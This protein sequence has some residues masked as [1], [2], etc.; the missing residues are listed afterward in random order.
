MFGRDP[1]LVGILCEP[2]G[3]HRRT[4]RTAII[5]INAGLIHRVG[6]NRVY[7]RLARHLASMGYQSLRF[8]LSGRGDSDVRRNAMGFIEGSLADVRA[9]MDLLR[10][11]IGAERFVLMGI[12]SG[13]IN[14]LHA[15]T[16]DPR[17]VGTIA[18]DGPAHQTF[19]YYA[20][21]YARRAL[22]G[23][24][25]LNILTGRNPLKRWLR[26]P[27]P[28]AAPARAEDE[29]AHLYGEL[30]LPSREESERVLQSVIDRG[31]RMLFIYTGS[32]SIYNYANQ[33]RDAFPELMKRGAIRV[34]YAPDADHT[35]T[36]PHH[37]Q[38][39]V[40]MVTAW[41]TDNFSDEGDT[42]REVADPATV[43]A[44]R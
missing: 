36:R 32:W 13:A 9:A 3:E 20:R 19:G 38:R 33:F 29:F 21:H 11:T 2:A 35:F 27:S 43:G 24:A 44:E 23:R 12:C 18:I 30:K 37:Q 42:S 17:V 28:A 22:S 41:V 4:R 5:F 34:E 10:E 25:W 15:A 40:D 39:L 26:R 14:S 1:R 6:P 7:V 31:A 16:Q 8:D